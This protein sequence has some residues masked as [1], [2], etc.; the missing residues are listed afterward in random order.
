MLART[1]RRLQPVHTRCVIVKQSAAL[2]AGEVDR[3]G[4]E[5][6][7]D[8]PNP[9]RSRAIANKVADFIACVK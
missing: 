6:V 9:L 8:V 3:D 4:F 2:V 1:M 5:C 7:K